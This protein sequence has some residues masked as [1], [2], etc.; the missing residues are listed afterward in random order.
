MLLI[1][2]V[3]LFIALYRST[4]CSFIV[5]SICNL[6]V[7]YRVGKECQ[8]PEIN[9]THEETDHRQILYL[10]YAKDK[11][12]KYSVVRSPGSDSF[13]L[14]LYYAH[15]LKPLIVFLDI[16]SGE[17]RKLLNIT[18]IANDFGEE[19]CCTLLGYYIFTGKDTTSAFR[20]KGKVNS[21]KKLLKKHASILCSKHW[22]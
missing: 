16:G 22:A 1:I 17:H 4:T 15:R 2:I 13:F 8:I 20:G 6:L 3:L 11:G 21:L 19:Y 10:F 9:S 7:W 18:D 5:I 12:Y 14:L